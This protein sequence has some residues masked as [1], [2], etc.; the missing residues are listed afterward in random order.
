MIKLLNLGCGTRYHDDWTNVDFISKNEKVLAFNLLNGIPFENNS[1]DVVYHSH[2]LEHFS[3]D[4]GKNFLLECSRVLK[5]GG[6]IRIAV[7]DLE[8]I[9]KEYL[10]NL[11]LA[12]K[13]DILAMHNYEWIILEMYDQVV[14]DVSG[15]N[16]A[17]Y[18]FQKEI[19]NQEYVYERLGEEGRSLRKSYVNNIVE[20]KNKKSI[21][22][23]TSQNKKRVSLPLFKKLKQKLIELIFQNEIQH[24]EKLKKETSIGKFRLGGEIHQWMYDRFS[25][26]KLLADI[27]FLNVEVKDAFN[28]NIKDWDKYELESKNGVIHKPD[29]LF[30]EAFK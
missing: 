1:F 12:L 11:D 17:K 15:G 6:V 20:L 9:A 27:G 18:I 22:S 2:V 5:P 24:F 4:E 10:K 30:I 23:K 29:S 16:M 7:P 26:A 14:R 3:K 25:L 13:G 21:S 28:S 19:P 8:I